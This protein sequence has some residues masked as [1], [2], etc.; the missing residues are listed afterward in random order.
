MVWEILALASLVLLIHRLTQNMWLAGALALACAVIE[1]VWVHGVIPEVYSLST[2]LF[3]WILLLTVN[4]SQGWSDKRGWV[5]ATLAGIGV[6]HHRLLALPIIPIGFFLLPKFIRAHRHNERPLYSIVRWIAIALICFIGG[7][8]PYLDIPLRIRLGTSWVYDYRSST[9]KGL[10]YVLW[11]NEYIGLMKPNLSW[12]PI[13]SS[14]WAIFQTLVRMFSLPGLMTIVIAAILGII[15]RHKRS[16]PV[17]GLLVAICGIYIIFNIIVQPVLLQAAIMNMLITL[18]ILA[19]VGLASLQSRWQRVSIAG[20]L[21]WAGWMGVRNYPFVISLTRDPSEVN[22]I[23][24]VE[25]TE[26]P[27]GSVVMAPWGGMYFSLA[28]AQRVEGRM[29]EWQIVDHRANYREL[30]EGA[31]IRV[32]THNSTLYVFGPEWWAQQLG[33]PLR[34]TSAGPE[35]VILTP[36]PLD[37]STKQI[38]LLGDGIVLND[39]AVREVQEGVLHL[40]TWWSAIS[41]PSR[42]YS[43]FAHLTDRDEIN[44]PEDLIAQVDYQAPVYG[45]YPTTKWALNEMI[46]EDRLIY[47]SP[48]RVPKTIF[49]GMY[50][51]DSE[52]RFLHLGKVTLRRSENLWIL[53]P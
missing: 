35:M 9:L 31:P 44:Q 46:R 41:P 26:A 53:A 1:P 47:F 22:F 45:W 17:A 49:V 2:A 32:Y 33:E 21:V 36:E 20:I 48:D 19:G 10:K 15:G 38:T 7:F 39:W 8:L 42:D 5:L 52:G 37:V 51:R 50:W 27:P 29:T 11:A 16:R 40:V 4:L 13:I 25:K 18:C 28:Y 12:H 23:S 30:L 34:I 24:L 43:T 14:S 6:A 3:V